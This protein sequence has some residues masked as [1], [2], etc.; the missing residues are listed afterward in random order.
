MTVA[1]ALF[2]Y[3]SAKALAAPQDNDDLDA[4][5]LVADANR[6][7]DSPSR[8]AGYCASR[9]PVDDGTHGGQTDPSNNT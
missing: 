6:D 1:L 5:R 8:G 9:G 2:G 4:A 3:F 7:P